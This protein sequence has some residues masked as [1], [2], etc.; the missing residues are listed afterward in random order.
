GD[1][2]LTGRGRPGPK[3]F[4]GE[5]G[6]QFYSP[7]EVRTMI[8]TTLQVFVDT[9][10]THMSDIKEIAKRI[11]VVLPKGADGIPGTPGPAGP[12]GE[13]GRQGPTGPPGYPGSPGPV[14]EPGESG[15]PGR[16][17]QPGPK[18]EAGPPGPVILANGTLIEVKGQKGDK[19]LDGEK[20]L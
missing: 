10:P 16:D 6:S 11:E 18:G 15:P 5:K 4:Q 20:G 13:E 2:G 1:R 14:G 3:G 19:G 7:E 12:K 17:G 9:N 8:L